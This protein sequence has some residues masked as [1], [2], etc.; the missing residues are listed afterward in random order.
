MELTPATL[1]L[2]LNVVIITGVTSL[3]VFCYQVKRE[4]QQ[5]IS[6][7]KQQL[8]A[9]PDPQG[10]QSVAALHALPATHP[11]IRKYVARRAADWNTAT[12]IPG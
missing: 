9:L 5:L 8:A 12:G 6:E 3:A 7:V 10:A 2:I 1:Q 11:D 4:T